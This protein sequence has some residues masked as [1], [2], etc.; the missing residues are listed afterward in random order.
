MKRD[1]E[2][3]LRVRTD[4]AGDVWLF[5]EADGGPKACINAMALATRLEESGL[6]IVPKAIRSWVVEKQQEFVK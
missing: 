2:S 3:T 5:F 4:V 1:R 6:T